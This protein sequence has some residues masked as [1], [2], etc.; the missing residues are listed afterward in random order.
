MAMGDIDLSTE[1]KHYYRERAEIIIENL[2]KKYMHGSYADTKEEALQQIFDL[3]PAGV[4]VGRG[5]SVTLNQLGVF[6]ALT[7]RGLNEF[8]NP[9]RTD[10]KTGYNPPREE[11]RA[12]QRQ[13]LLSDVYLTSTNAITME[14]T[15]VSTDGSGNRVAA[16]CFGP[17]KVII[18]TG[19]NKICHDVEDALRRIRDWA[20]PINALRHRLK[21]AKDEGLGWGVLRY[22]AIIDGNQPVEEGK[23]HV[24][25]VGENLGL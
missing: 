1:I 19:C 17:K 4:K 7:E 23:I 21:H 11:R 12:M 6:E 8:T 18:V 14:G 5:D 2:K 16:M 10:A 3:I 24:I 25:L 13:V 15:I 20:G 9:V 22:T